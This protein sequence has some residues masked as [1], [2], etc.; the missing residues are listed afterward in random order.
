MV[1][2]E[3]NNKKLKNGAQNHQPDTEGSWEER[4]SVAR[5]VYREWMPI[6][7]EPYASYDVGDL[8]TLFRLDTR[9]EGRDEQLDL[10]TVLAGKSDPEAAKKALANFRDG[11]WADPERQLL[12]ERQE[13]WLGEGLAASTAR[14]A[15]WQVLVQQVLMGEFM[16]PTTLLDS[17]PDN[18][19]DF[20]R[21]RFVNGA[22]ASEAGIPANMDAWDGYPAAR[23]RA[24][25][26]ALEAD[27]NLLVLAGDTHNGWAFELDL[28][29][30]KTGIEFGVQ[31]V[32]SPGME[33]SLSMIAPSDVAAATVSAND[34][35]KW[36]DSSQRGYLTVEL[37]PTRATTEYRF[38]A[39]VKTRSTKLA[40]TKRI[41][42]EAGSHKLDL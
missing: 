33:S 27:A 4:L 18:L 9:I 29:G 37:T 28:D 8:A 39:G 11:A 22:M 26:M 30:E 41:S 6:S 24:F 34:Q 40:G 2:H 23:E 1:V 38:V 14:G 5:R 12:G 42:S 3:T 17:M 7:D 21:Q 25:K 20:L 10:R 13:R 31:G 15:T 16:I 36:V 32:T 19:P 35:L